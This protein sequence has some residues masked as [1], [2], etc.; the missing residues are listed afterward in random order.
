MTACIKAFRVDPLPCL[1]A[2]AHKACTAP[3]TFSAFS[4][5]AGKESGDLERTSQPRPRRARFQA[6]GG[7]CFM[8]AADPG[9]PLKPWTAAQR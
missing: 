7:P 6:Q 2:A 4:T 8:L 3:W 1:V 5:R 9:P